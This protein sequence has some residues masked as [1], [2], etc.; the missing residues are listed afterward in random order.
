MGTRKKP[1]RPPELLPDERAYDYYTGREDG[2]YTMLEVR[3]RL[4]VGPKMLADL[5]AGIG[6]SMDELPKAPTVG[7]ARLMHWWHVEELAQEQMRRL[8][9]ARGTDRVWLTMPEVAEIVGFK[10]TAAANM[11]LRAWNARLRRVDKRLCINA[12]DL[13]R[14]LEAHT[15]PGCER[16][17]ERPRGWIGSKAAA[18]MLNLNYNAG[19]LYK[20]ATAG[21]LRC[22]Y[23]CRCRYWD[24]EEVRTLAAQ[25][26]PPPAGWV[27]I[28]EISG[29]RNGDYLLKLLDRA[30]LPYARHRPPS[31]QRL[32]WYTS[33]EG[34]EL[35]RNRKRRPKKKR[36]E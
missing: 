8:D 22:R 23:Y 6:L 31:G 5:M 16:W 7:T 20:L 9:Y 25:Y 35:L 3:E 12:D 26:T 14:L 19:S 18:E 21:K 33:P 13:D 27:S 4:G 28:Y 17:H 34:A 11:S 30:G 15:P 29:G 36:E 1:A 24:P 2:M 10:S 32:T